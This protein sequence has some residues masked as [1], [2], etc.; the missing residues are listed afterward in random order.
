MKAK[1]TSRSRPKAP[2]NLK[3]WKKGTSGN[4]KGRPKKGESWADLIKTI[5]DMTG[6]EIAEEFAYLAKTLRQYPD[7]VTLRT[8]IV[9]RALVALVNEP[10][11]AL[12]REIMDRT[13]GKVPDRLETHGGL[14]IVG[15]EEQLRKIY[16]DAAE[17][18]EEVKDEV[19]Q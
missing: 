4:P 3:P 9:I 5:S 2:A 19:P 7:N 13:D 1:R 8:L 10:N 18:E 11:T 16:G 14:S 12:F 15:F 6:P 17:A